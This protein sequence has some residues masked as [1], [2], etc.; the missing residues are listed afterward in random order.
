MYVF[1]LA[2]AASTSGVRQKETEWVLPS[3]DA[4]SGWGMESIVGD[5]AISG[6]LATGGATTAIGVSFFLIESW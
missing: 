1:G 2:A 5:G 6:K 3:G 4:T